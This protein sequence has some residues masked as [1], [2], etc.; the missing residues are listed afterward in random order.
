[1]RYISHL[2]FVRLSYRA[3]R[4]AELPYILTKGFNPRPKISFGRALKL[5]VEEG[6][7]E[8]TFFLCQEIRL[9]EFK[10]RLEEQLPS[11]IRIIELKYE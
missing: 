6:Q 9:E 10:R 1:M 11:D 3:L 2:D 5:G 8:A 7:V 4:R